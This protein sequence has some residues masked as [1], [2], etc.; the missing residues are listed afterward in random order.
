MKQGFRVALY[1]RVSTD[2]KGQDPLNQLAQLRDFVEKQG[3]T[4]TKEYVDETSGKD[5]DRPAFKLLWQDAERHRFDVLL[6]WSLDRFTR[7]GTLPTLV[8][9]QRL[10]ANGIKY[11][12]YT[13]Q[14]IDS[15]GPWADA[16]IGFIATLNQMERVRI[17]TRVKAGLDRA[18][19]QG[20]KF[21][22]PRVSDAKASRTTLWRRGKG[23]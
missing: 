23:N 2:D 1:A 10:T 4:I 5:G 8:Y 20:A 18:R 19:R 7:E 9:L 14:W 11:K 15:L 6:F 13:E 21:G 12:S 16:F 22:R 17:S 3:W